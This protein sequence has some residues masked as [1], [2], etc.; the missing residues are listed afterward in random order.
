MI[1]N[2]I[3]LM[4]LAV[5][6][7][8]GEERTAQFVDGQ[9]LY[10]NWDSPWVTL[11]S[12]IDRNVEH[13]VIPDGVTHN[14]RYYPL[15]EIGHDAFRGMYNLTDVTFTKGYG[16]IRGVFKDCPRLSVIKINDTVPPVIGQHPFYGG[17]LTDVFEPYHLE[18]TI[19]VVPPGAEEIYR[20]AEGWREFKHIQSTWPTPEEYHLEALDVRINTIEQ[21]LERAKRIVEQLQQELDALRQSREVKTNN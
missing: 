6:G 7:F 19:I 4:I 9:F 3:S 8:F 10:S 17:K 20:N 12:C 14:G 1:L 15:A 11:D 13:L 5:I 16:I 21:E 18:G 2:Y